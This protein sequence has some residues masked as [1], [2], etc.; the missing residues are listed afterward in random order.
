MSSNT[1]YKILFK[2]KFNIKIYENYNFDLK[3]KIFDIKN[4][5]NINIIDTDYDLYNLVNGDPISILMPFASPFL[6]SLV[7]KKKFF[8]VDFLNIYKNS[9]FSSYDDL[10]KY[11]LSDAIQYIDILRNIPLKEYSK[12]ISKLYFD[13]F[14]THEDII[15]KKNLY[16]FLNKNNQR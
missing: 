10:I 4:K 16:N 3:R 9:F 1:E 11:N 7:K 8:F 15:S 14:D 5:K 2:S 6:V 13:T 12:N